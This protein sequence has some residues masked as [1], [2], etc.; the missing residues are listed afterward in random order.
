MQNN[1]IDVVSPK[2]AGNETGPH[3]I[4]KSNIQKRQIRRDSIN[5]TA[6]WI[7]R[8][9]T[10]IIQFLNVLFNIRTNNV[11]PTEKETIPR[12]KFKNKKSIAERRYGEF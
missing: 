1:N 3:I 2:A 7:A 6:N 8:E 5:E 4:S 12:Y 9:D 10:I 11:L